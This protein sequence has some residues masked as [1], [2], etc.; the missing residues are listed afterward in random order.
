MYEKIRKWLLAA[1]YATAAVGIFAALPSSPASSAGV[2]DLAVDIVRASNYFLGGQQYTLTVRN[3]GDGPTDGTAVTVTVDLPTGLLLN[4]ISGSG[5]TCNNLTDTCTRSDVLA[6]G[7][8]YPVITVTSGISLLVD[9]SLTATATVTGGGDGGDESAY[10]GFE[11]PSVTISPSGSGGAWAKTASATIDV[12]QLSLGLGLDPG[13]FR[14]MWTQSPT[15]PDASDPGWSSFADGESVTLSGEDGAWYLHAVAGDVAGNLLTVSTDAFFLDNTAPLPAVPQFVTD[16]GGTYSVASW[17]NR[18]VLVDWGAADT[19]GSGV[20]T[21]EYSLDGK[22]TWWPVSGFT[23]TEGMH[24]VFFRATDAVG[25]YADTTA[26]NIYIDMTPP[27][28]DVTLTSGEGDTYVSDTW[29]QE[30]VTLAASAVDLTTHVPAAD[31]EYSVDGGE[32]FSDLTG[33]L[34]FATSGVRNV[35]V[36]AKDVAG[37]LATFASVVKVDKTAPTLTYVMEKTNGQDYTPGTKSNQAV[38]FRSLAANDVHSGIAYVQYSLNGGGSWL[39]IGSFTSIHAN[40]NFDLR[41]RAYDLVGNVYDTSTAVEVE[42]LTPVI[43]LTP[44]AG[45][46]NVGIHVTAGVSNVADGLVTTKW[47]AGV[48]D[49]AYF[50]TEGTGFT[51]VFLA[52]ENGVYTVYA[53]D[54]IGN[55]GVQT[56]TIDRVVRTPPTLALTVS[57]EAATNESVAVH[58]GAAVYGEEVGNALQVVKWEEGDIADP[59]HFAS[60][61]DDI[62]S[63]LSFQVSA[64]GTYTVYA[65]DLAGNET[66]TTVNVTNIDVVTPSVTVDVAPGAPTNGPVTA[67]VTATVYGESN[68]I[69][70][71]RWEQDGGESSDL[72]F[73]EVEDG[74]PDRRTYLATAVATTNGTYAVTVRDTFGNEKTQT[75]GIGNILTTPPIVTLTAFPAPPET[76]E[77]SVNVFV[78]AAAVGS[79]NGIAVLKWAPGL[80]TV[81]DFDTVEGYVS[82]VDAFAI[83]AE[84]NGWFTVFAEDLAGNRA[85]ASIEVTN[86]VS[87]PP[88]ASPTLRYAVAYAH[89]DDSVVKLVFDR[90]LEKTRTLD[91]AAFSFAGVN[92]SAAMAGYDAADPR[93]V[94][95]ALAATDE[96]SAI[97]WSSGASLS[98]GAGAV[99]SAAGGLNEVLAGFRIVTPAAVSAAKAAIDPSGGGVGMAQLVAYLRQVGPID[100]DGDGYAD[101]R[102]LE[103]LLSFLP[104]ISFAAHEE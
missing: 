75:V 4:S 49:A 37:N 31:F 19:G 16:L 12:T 77:G 81:S 104:A 57:P 71:L 35:V 40:G 100:L 73:E 43:A 83:T 47:A 28:L 69:E 45:P 1:L 66:L 86:I 36:R 63:S 62:T 82:T 48:R 38:R 22:Q 8:V 29:V 54:S 9:P 93:A 11:L 65:K 5:W 7:G 79:M 89:G 97:V 72:L 55:E 98:L 20:S 41:I 13:L 58:V 74:D 70:W 90:P 88:E 15:P 96:S 56:I 67:T 91:A 59:E 34:T 24:A 39:P 6:A 42:I 92:A 14:Y 102:D 80:Y 60:A 61:G 46:S 33:D 10:S 101:R 21:L 30:T 44:S 85:A 23:L 3:V 27:E 94:W 25:N 87:V 51:G 53:R 99:R 84:A 95:V 52:T 64:N 50:A 76:T 2:P 18:T 78:S 103:I 68:G 17:T 26:Y 32:T